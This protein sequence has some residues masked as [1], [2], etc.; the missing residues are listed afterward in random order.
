M[1]ILRNGSLRSKSF[2]SFR[3]IDVQKRGFLTRRDFMTFLKDFLCAW[4][5]ITNIAICK[6][7]L[8]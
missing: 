7:Q 1:D 5:C 2:L 6:I 4:S 3:M 8:G